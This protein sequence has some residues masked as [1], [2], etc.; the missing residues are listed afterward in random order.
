MRARLAVVLMACL[1]A[2]CDAGSRVH[3]VRY[4]L[5]WTWGRAHAASGNGGWDV[6][7]DRGYRVHVARGWLTSYSVELVECPRTP[8]PPA[9]ALLWG[10]LA[11]FTV[12]PAYAAHEVGTPNPAAINTPHVESLDQ[13]V[14]TEVGAVMLRP[15]AYCQAHYLIARASRA[16]QGLPAAVDMVDASLYLEGTYQAPAAGNAVP[17]TVRTPVA[18]G[19]QSDLFPPDRYGDETAA[20]RVDTGSEG[21]VVVVRRNLATLFDGIDFATADERRIGRQ[22]LTN[23]INTITIEIEV[24]RDG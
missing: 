2:G 6:V 4:R 12:R 1:V 10:A 13:P 7:T 21:A 9:T 8:P 22:V 11:A 19:V 24:R 23:L 5:D 3:E 16:A 18:N 20:L 17:F 14:A 15:Q